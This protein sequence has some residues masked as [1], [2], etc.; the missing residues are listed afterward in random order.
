MRLSVW[1]GGFQRRAG[2]RSGQQ[3]T[4]PCLADP[5]S[6]QLAPTS[7]PGRISFNNWLL[8]RLSRETSSGR[9]IPEMDG[10]RFAAIGMVVLFHL[11]GYL[12]GKSQRYHSSPPSSDWLAQAAL[13]GFRGVELFFVISG[14]ILGLPFAAQHIEGRPPVG[15][16]KYYVRRLTRLEPPY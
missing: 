11:N 14:F 5:S 8:A 1:S 2:R 4:G 13:V 7:S 16:R 9:F 10:L 6:S 12:I 3:P 15:L